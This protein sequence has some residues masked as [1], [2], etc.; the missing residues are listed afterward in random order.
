MVV[1][2]VKGRTRIIVFI[3]VN[4]LSRTK[5]RIR[6]FR[7]KTHKEMIEF[8][9]L[10]RHQRRPEFSRRSIPR[11]NIYYCMI[12]VCVILYYSNI[13]Y[14]YTILTVV[15][16]CMAVGRFSAKPLVH[17]ASTTDNILYYTQYRLPRPVWRRGGYPN[18][19]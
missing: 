3:Y 17:G 12:Y 2:E 16:I 15:H 1:A 10:F 8:R 6:P 4:Y 19:H 18:G 13:V 7:N 11:R 5:I 14:K 9:V